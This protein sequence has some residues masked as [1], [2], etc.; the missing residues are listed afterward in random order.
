VARPGWFLAHPKW[1]VGFSDGTVLHLALGRSG[2]S[3]LHAANVTGLGKL[4]EKDWAQTVACLEGQ[5]QTAPSDLR[6]CN[7]RAQNLASPELPPVLGGNLTVLFA[8]AVAGRLSLSAGCTLLLED[9]SETSYRID[10]MLTALLDGGHFG[11]LGALVLGDFWQCSEGKFN[12]PSE[13]V[14]REH[15]SPLPLPVFSGA[16]VG[17]GAVNA[18]VVLGQPLPVRLQLP[19]APS[20]SST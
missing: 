14:L 16:A 17:H 20:A 13:Q 6:A 5:P 10:R 1:F 8:E 9:V 3:S 12:V 4:S 2:F 18:P 7:A 15:L 11:A 19:A